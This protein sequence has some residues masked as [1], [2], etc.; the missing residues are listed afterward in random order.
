MR[1]GRSLALWGAATL[2][3]GIIVFFTTGWATGFHDPDVRCFES[4][5]LEEGVAPA[6]RGEHYV[7]D[8]ET[9]AETQHLP[10]GVRCTERV[11][12][13]EEGD[14]RNIG[15]TGS[16][17]VAAKTGDWLMLV[18]LSLTGG[19]LL[20]G[21]ALALRWTARRLG[22]WTWPPPRN[23]FVWIDRKQ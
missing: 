18:G 9:R 13:V 3:V 12:D 19:L 15:K 16:Y 10:P 20:A 11:A 21:A 14:P 1:V 4:V 22:Y 8:I 6:P 7:W 5:S 17:E 23:P 2:L